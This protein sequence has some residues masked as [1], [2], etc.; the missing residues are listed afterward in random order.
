MV[1]ID[2]GAH[3]D[4]YIVVAAHTV[5]VKEAPVAG[6]THREKETDRQTG[7]ERKR[8]IH[9][10]IHIHTDRHLHT[11]IHAQINT[12][13]QRLIHAYIHKLTNFNSH[14]FLYYVS[15]PPSQFSPHVSVCIN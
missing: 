10:L 13:K 4:G 5:I 6:N 15:S 1:K 11:L 8:C 3:M 7:R 14:S 2:L 9:T 12:H